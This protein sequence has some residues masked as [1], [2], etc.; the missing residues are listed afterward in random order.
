MTQ[1]LRKELINHQQG[2]LRHLQQH[3]GINK[4][5][6]R[7]EYCC[8]CYPLPLVI[9]EQFKHFWCWYSSY[10]THSYSGQTIQHFLSLVD[11]V[12][13]NLSA[14]VIEVLVQ[15]LVFSTVFTK[16]PTDYEIISLNNLP[17]NINLNPNK[18]KLKL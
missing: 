8:S 9:P 18:L 3:Q 16:A 4:P 14:T 2:A 7:E 11:A 6:T 1:Y 5:T 17:L 10:Y 13:N 12:Q 15:R